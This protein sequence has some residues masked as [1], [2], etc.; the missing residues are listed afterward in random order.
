LRKSRRF[1]PA[2]N[3]GK[4]PDVE[5]LAKQAGIDVSLAEQLMA[6]TMEKVKEMRSGNR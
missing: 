6:N 4:K 5:T 1:A 2:I 3:A